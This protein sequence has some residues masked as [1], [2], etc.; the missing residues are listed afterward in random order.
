MGYPSLNK[1]DIKKK[2][3]SGKKRETLTMQALS[4]NMAS[5]KRGPATSIN[6]ALEPI[7]LRDIIL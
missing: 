6:E 1:L 4:E 3:I 2:G 7:G 5:G